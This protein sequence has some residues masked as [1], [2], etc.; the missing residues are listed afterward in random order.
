MTELAS[1][2]A[3]G[4][5]LAAAGYTEDGIRKALGIEG[6]LGV[7]GRAERSF[8]ERR[9]PIGEALS[10][11]IRLCFLGLPVQEARLSAVIDTHALAELG[12]ADAS[13][14]TLMPRVT[15][16]AV[17]NTLA[18]HDRE[19]LDDMREDH[20]VGVGPAPRSLASLTVRMPVESALDLGTG[21]GIQ[22]LL[23]A[24]HAKQVTATDISQRALDFAGLNAALNGVGNI[25]WLRGDLFAPVE[26]RTFDL[27]VA[28]PPFV[29]SPDRTYVFRDSGRPTDSLSRQVVEQAPRYLNEGGFAHLLCSWVAGSRETWAETPTKWLEGTGCDAWLLCNQ[30][31]EPEVY[32]ANWQSH[33]RMDPETHAAAV[34]RWA[35]F[36]RSEGIRYICTGALLLRKH[37]GRNWV[38]ADM[39]PHRPRGSA[40]D[41]I[42]RVFAAQ[43]RLCEGDAP[44]RLLDGVFGPIDG[45]W[46]DQRTLYRR[47]RYEVADAYL[48]LE[49]GAGVSGSV[50]A[51]ATQ[52]LFRLDGRRT[53]RSVISQAVKETGLDRKQ[54]TA[55]ALETV[56]GL[57]G[58]GLVSWRR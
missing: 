16:A 29:I 22:A 18:A 48:S 20:V 10:D 25:E 2:R 42:L 13:D 1:A 56:R 54:L 26:G 58:L 45:H 21:C 27:I 17:G 55:A 35:E 9:L 49:E 3:L 30:V 32:A 7:P 40:S 4:A 57:A 39:M 14:G 15:I 19:G 31:E 43:D 24:A 8:Y 53:L 52:V 36:Y 33:L 11:L 23:L 46:L 34:Q 37:S 44:D 51:L 41:H 12:L 5:A 6:L 38:R 28:N 47:G 50:A